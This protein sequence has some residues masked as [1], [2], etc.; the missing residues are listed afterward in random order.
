MNPRFPDEYDERQI[1]KVRTRRFGFDLWVTSRFLH[2]YAETTYEEMTATLVRQMARRSAC[3]I[4]VGAHFGFYSVL[5]GLSNP[6][7]S[8][9]AFEPVPENAGILRK[10]LEMHSIQG[11]VRE[12]AISDRSGQR[13]FQV[14][15]ASDNSGFIANPKGGLLK[16]IDMETTPLDAHRADMPE[17]PAIVKIDTEGH[18]L[19]VVNGMRE[20]LRERNDVRLVIEFNP[21]CLAANGVAPER[22]LETIDD[23]GFEMFVVHDDSMSLQR[24]RGGTPWQELIGSKSYVNILCI[25]ADLSLHV[26]LISH[27]SGLEGAERSLLELVDSLISERGSLCTVVLPSDGPLTSR[28]NEA[29]AA[30]LRAEFGWW[31][32]GGTATPETTRQQMALSCSE[33]LRLASVV[34]RVRP[35]VVVTNTLVIPWGALT[36]AILNIPHIWWVKEFGEV[37]H[38]LRFFLDFHEV[39]RIIQESSNHV[40]AASN[41]VRDLLF[42]E[43][44]HDRC[45]VAY[46]DKVVAPAGPRSGSGFFRFPHSTKLLFAGRATEA[47]GLDD[48][49]LALKTLVEGYHDVE[50]CVIGTVNTP[51]GRKMQQLVSEIGLTDRVHF[52]GFVENVREVI[53]AADVVLMCSKCEAFGRITAE[54]MLLGRPVVGTNTGGTVELIDDG[55]TG[56]L[57]SPGNSD[58]LA[59]RIRFFVDRP[60]AAREFGDC[61]RISIAAK[62]DEKPVSELMYTVCRNIKGA[63]NPGAAELLM[64]LLEWQ[65]AWSDDLND[66]IGSLRAELD[67]GEEQSLAQ[68]ARLAAVESDL[69]VTERRARELEALVSERDRRV[70]A[71]VARSVEQERQIQELR[72]E[73]EDRDRQVESLNARSSSLEEQMET[74]KVELRERSDQIGTMTRQLDDITKSRAWRM[75]NLLWRL[76]TAVAPPDSLR[77]RVLNR[78]GL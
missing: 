23:L 63:P 61:A 45:S 22:L 8:V 77:G 60:D 35:D 20:L 43:L 48:A 72:T 17:G 74:L 42:A 6:D 66:R 36:A 16:T 31:C 78:L 53:E 73:L 32:S 62:L 27:S 44:D 13:P 14:S 56:F 1:T 64:F 70:E 41:A 57:Y 51:F 55:V 52:S 38:D 47:K 34:D 26:C 58:A 46:N 76:R 3:F 2:H 28:L 59:D 25:P 33:V 40:I 4:D 10:N 69:E 21:A 18:E 39:I 5:V 11:E 71:V 12:A 49:I 24:F 50:L 15:C 7:C 75:A 54:A 19:Q 37:D 30:T 67:A 65:S 9:F 29:G 68:S